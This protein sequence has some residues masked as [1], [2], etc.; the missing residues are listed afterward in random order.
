MLDTAIPSSAPRRRRGMTAA[1]LAVATLV[2]TVPPVFARPGPE[3]FSDLAEKVKP[4]V[5]NIST[6]QRVGGGGGGGPP[7]GGGGGRPPRGPAAGCVRRAGLAAPR[8]MKTRRAGCGPL[9]ARALSS[10]PRATS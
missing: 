2:F 7:A 3:G 10:M 9:S 4:A 6:T 8:A 5:V 1:A